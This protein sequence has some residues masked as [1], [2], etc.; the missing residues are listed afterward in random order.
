MAPVCFYYVCVLFVYICCKSRDETLIKV[1]FL[2]C[3]AHKISQPVTFDWSACIKPWE[4]PVMCDFGVSSDPSCVI[5]GCR[6][7]RHVWFWS[8]EWPVMCD[9]GVS[10]D[11]SCVILGVD[12]T[13]VSKI[14]DWNGELFRWCVY[15]F[16]YWKF[17]L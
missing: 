1:F 4:W 9:F 12:C 3:L 6:V 7:T 16:I 15:F 13:S 8:V 11:P 14:S 2:S 17:E 10:S 5:L